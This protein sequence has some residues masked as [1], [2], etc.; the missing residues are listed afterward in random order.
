ME[1]CCLVFLSPGAWAAPWGENACDRGPE[2]S[3]NESAGS[4]PREGVEMCLCVGEATLK[5]LM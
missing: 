4:P 3:G 5:V 1:K 2:F